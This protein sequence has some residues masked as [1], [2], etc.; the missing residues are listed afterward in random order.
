MMPPLR[1]DHFV[2]LGVVEVI[3][4]EVVESLQISR[5]FLLL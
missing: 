4:R 3:R 2:L 1:E 5:D